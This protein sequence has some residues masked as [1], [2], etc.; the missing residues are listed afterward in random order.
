MSNER[1][2]R[3]QPAG[4]PYPGEGP[5][6]TTSGAC[7]PPSSSAPGL[8]LHIA[9]FPEHLIAAHEALIE[10]CRALCAD[11]GLRSVTGDE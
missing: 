8:P 7:S 10:R 11:G 5:P 3:G 1:R 6:R 4:G 2:R 9:V